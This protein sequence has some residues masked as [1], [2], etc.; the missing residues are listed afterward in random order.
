MKRKTYNTKSK[1]SRAVANNTKTDKKE[2]NKQLPNDLSDKLENSFGQD[3][4]N[5]TLHKDSQQAKKLNALAFTKGE[6]IHFAPGQFNPNTERGKNLIGHEF[7][8]IIQQR[9]GT[10]KPTMKLGKGMVGNE[11]RGLENE[12]DY[13]GKKAAKG[14]PISKYRSSSLGIRNSLRTVQTK[15]EVVQMLKQPT[16][17]G[18]FIDESYTTVKNSAGKEIGVEMYMKFHPG[19]NVNA[20]LIGM[21]QSVRSMDQGKVVSLNKTIKSRS[22]TAKDA[23][24][25]SSPVK[26]TDEGVHIDQAKYNRNPLYAVEKAPKTD[27]K[28][29]QGKTPSPVTKMTAA[30]L[31]ASPVSGKSYKGWGEHGYRYK[32]GK[33]WKKKDA[34]LH[35]TPQL[36]ARTKNAEQLFE[37]T[38]LAVDGVQQGTYYGSVQWG[39]RTDNKAKFSRIPFKVKSLGTPSST[40]LKAAGIWNKTK[41]SKGVS[42]L[43]LPTVDVKVIN[44]D[45]VGLFAGP[46]DD[47]LGVPPILTLPRGTRIRIISSDIAIIEIRVV[48][49]PLT[50]TTGYIN[51]IG[52]QYSDERS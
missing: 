38:A 28:L 25:I 20:K 8:H 27:T 10:V 21:V 32:S 48:D 2:S 15:S 6:N 18:E 39:W 23:A 13:F 40:F 14:E 19:N 49:G 29:S 1:G 16:H 51:D 3:F 33:S 7:T 52:H 5:V 50:G 36:S 42:S 9:S 26:G 44:Q 31:A 11:D 35:D 34:E 45:H 24:K 43:D 41:T 12:A 37:T 46:Y 17:F 30:E 22:I 4:S 47:I